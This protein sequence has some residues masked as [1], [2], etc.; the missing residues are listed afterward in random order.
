[1][2]TKTCKDCGHTWTDKIMSKVIISVEGNKELEKA[3]E[4]KLSKEL[5]VKCP[6]CGSK[7]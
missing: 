4:K 3:F 2:K 7:S 1:M 6:N 5:L